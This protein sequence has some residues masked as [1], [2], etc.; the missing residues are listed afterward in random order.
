MVTIESNGYVEF[1]WPAPDAER[2]EVVG[3]FHGWFEQAI[4]LTRDADGVW[5]VRLKLGAGQY[6]YRYL[7]DG[8]TWR[9][10]EEA[11]GRCRSVDGYVKSR[12]WL[13]PARQDPDALAA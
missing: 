8:E 4:P 6:L 11:H 3:A 9:V 1:S 13:P 12:L 5:S 2:V 7:V 10:D